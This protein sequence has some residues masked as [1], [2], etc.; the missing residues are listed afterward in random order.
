MNTVNIKTPFANWNNLFSQQ[1]LELI[2]SYVTT[3]IAPEQGIIGSAANSQTNV[4]IRKSTVYWVTPNQDIGWVF[5]RINTVG[6]KL[7]SH[8]FGFDIVPLQR[9]QYTVY[10]DCGGHYDWHTDCFIESGLDN[11]TVNTQRKLSLVAMCQQ[12]QEG[13]QIQLTL[14]GSL[15]EPEMSAGNA[16]VFPSFI[17]HR[18]V[19]VT[20]GTR[21]TLVA[22]FEGPDW[23]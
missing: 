12:P 19:P 8:F 18:V 4:D 11:L 1:E 14:G 15:M 20:S 13:G 16:I 9:L 6:F 5:D 23:R 17:L 7:N 10:E 3:N 2:D 22:W 21:K